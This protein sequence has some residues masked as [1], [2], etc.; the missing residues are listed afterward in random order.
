MSAAPTSRNDNAR[1]QA[2][3]VGNANYE[4]CYSALIDRLRSD[5]EASPTPVAQAGTKKA[6]EASAEKATEAA[7]EKGAEAAANTAADTAGT[8]AADAAGTA[9]ADATGTAAT[10]AIATQVGDA[11][12]TTATTEAGAAAGTAAAAEGATAAGSAMA[13]GLGTAA[14][15]IGTA[16]PWIGAAMAVGSLLE[17]WSDGGKAGT[18]QKD[19]VDVRGKGGKVPGEWSGNR[20]TVPALLVEGEGI[21]NSEA[22]KLLGDKGLAALNKKGLDLRRKGE[23][24]KTIKTV[25]LSVLLN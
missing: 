18:Q 12:L 3:E 19:G 24:P 10:G 22:T 7:A 14:T 15:A 11:A 2:G 20:D 25:G 4:R 16:M 8:A 17:L 23:T 9:A 13:S 1:G 5:T 21:L 6:A